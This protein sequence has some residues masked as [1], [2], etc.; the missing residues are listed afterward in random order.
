MLVIRGLPPSIR[1][2]RLEK[3]GVI[4]LLARPVTRKND[5]QHLNDPSPIVSGA[6]GYPPGN[7]SLCHKS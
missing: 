4:K 2:G 6:G 7:S 3:M 5:N 1:P